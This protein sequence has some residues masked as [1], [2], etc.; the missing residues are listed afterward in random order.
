MELE[1]PRLRRRPLAV[2]SHLT[3]GSGGLFTA[4]QAK[5]AGVDNKQLQRLTAAGA[6][7][8]EA[9]GTYRLV[10]S[11]VV[12]AHRAAI[13]RQ[14]VAG[15]VSHQTAAQLWGYS[16]A[17]FDGQT[18]HLTVRHACRASRSAGIVV[19][20]T[21]RSLE[22]FTTTRAGVEVTRPLRTVLDVSGQELDDRQ[23]QGFLDFCVVGRLLTIRSLERY[24][25]LKGRGVPGLARLRRVVGGLCEVESVAEAELV[26]VLV[27]AGVERPVTQFVIRAQGSFLGRVDLAWP[28]RHVALE[29]DGYRFHSDARAFV[30]DR[31]R[32][33]RIV[34]AGWLLL[35]TTPASVRRSPEL[36]VSDVRAALRRSTAA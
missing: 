5:A 25:A 8:R 6:L 4:A 9:R 27:A 16:G 30:S 28:G 1:R 12:L 3:L 11:Q 33:N 15:V 26:R 10:G 19:H 2:L 22:A 13:A 14:R 24:L 34:A 29:L 21:R 7:I 20:R 17:G 32:G 23:L 35:R 36:V 31:E 18:V